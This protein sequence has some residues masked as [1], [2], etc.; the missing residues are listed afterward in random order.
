VMMALRI[1]VNRELE[2]LERLLGALP[3]LLR[4]SARVAILTYHSL[5]ARLVKQAWRAQAAAGL[6]ELLT[7]SPLKPTAEQVRENPR[8]RTAQLRAARRL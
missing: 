8:V 3:E 2:E 5:E 6:L 1:H 4:P 7:P